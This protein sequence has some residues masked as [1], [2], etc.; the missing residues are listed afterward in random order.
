MYYHIHL[1]SLYLTEHDPTVL[2]VG[3]VDFHARAGNVR[4]DRSQKLDQVGTLAFVEQIVLGVAG[5]LRFVIRTVVMRDRDD[6]LGAM[7][8]REHLDVVLNRKEVG[9]RQ[10]NARGPA[11]N[12]Y[13]VGIGDTKSAFEEFLLGLGE[14][15]V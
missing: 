14:P 2:H 6:T 13:L 15:A 10:Q 3:E 11:R 8:F 1:F 9:T 12:R 5:I 7:R 4:A